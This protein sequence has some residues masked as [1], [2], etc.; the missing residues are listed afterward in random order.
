MAFWKL[1][2]TGNSQLTVSDLRN[3]T[4]GACHKSSPS[5]LYFPMASNSERYA[6]DHEG[7]VRSYAKSKVV[8]MRDI[9][10][11]DFIIA[12]VLVVWEF[13]GYCMRRRM[14]TK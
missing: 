1:R 2:P 10:Q 13:S 4:C 11:D 7:R 6:R 8:E 12:I 9:F 5:Q 14:S 3:P